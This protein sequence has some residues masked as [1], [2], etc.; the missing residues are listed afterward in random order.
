VHPSSF[1]ASPSKQASA[2]T[3]AR[4]RAHIP[5]PAAAPRMETLISSSSLL[6]PEGRES[7][8]VTLMAA[9]ATVLRRTSETAVSSLMR[10]ERLE[11]KCLNDNWT[12]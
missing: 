12:D 6:R 4:H 7:G 8:A 10:P 5:T 3:T 11:R 9:H 2:A 1:T